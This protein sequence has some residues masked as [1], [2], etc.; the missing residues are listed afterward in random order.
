MPSAGLLIAAA[1][2]LIV[3]LLVLRLAR[4]YFHMRG[5]R[6]VTCPENQHKAG[7]ELDARAA[8]FSG[9]LHAPALR[10]RSCTR[11]PEKQDCGQECLRQVAAAGED[12]LLRNMLAA[13]YQGKSCA[14]CDRP[15]GEIDWASRKPGLMTP[16]GSFTGWEQVDPGQIDEVLATHRPVCFA[17]HVANAFAKEHPELIVDRSARP[18]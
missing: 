3:V 18:R 9:V 16:E 15:F 7:V 1:A 13:W 10:L 11:W 14:L 2:A 5:A 6:V 12:C 4:T 17:C 8:A